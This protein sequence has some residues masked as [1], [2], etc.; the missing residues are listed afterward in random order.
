MKRGLQF[1]MY[2]ALELKSWFS[3]QHFGM[4]DTASTTEE[5]RGAATDTMLPSTPV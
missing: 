3:P 2:P 5:I 1:A 4:R